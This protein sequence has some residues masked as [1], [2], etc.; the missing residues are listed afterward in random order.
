MG[1]KITLSVGPSYPL[2]F[3]QPLS[4]SGAF[5][6]SSVLWDHNGIFDFL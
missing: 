3:D 6:C 2:S 1:L 4:L 5:F